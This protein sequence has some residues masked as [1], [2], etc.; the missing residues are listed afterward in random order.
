MIKRIS[1]VFSFRV[2]NLPFFTPSFLLYTPLHF[3]SLK[4]ISILI[5]TSR[6][7][8]F[9]RLHLFLFCSCKTLASL[10]IGTNLDDIHRFKEGC[11]PPGE[12]CFISILA[13]LW[14]LPMHVMRILR[15]TTDRVTKW[16]RIH[17][18]LRWKIWSI[19]TTSAHVTAL[20]SS[21]C[22]TFGRSSSFS[23][24]RTYGILGTGFPPKK[25]PCFWP[26]MYSTQ[27]LFVIRCWNR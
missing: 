19:G 9:K 1:G 12:R 24:F 27:L 10:L 20:L 14:P 15:L 8:T 17:M 18:Y 13:C 4:V 25:K 2:V 21:S 6:T 7:F 26:P 23:S 11:K 5:S 16:R 22:K 3:S